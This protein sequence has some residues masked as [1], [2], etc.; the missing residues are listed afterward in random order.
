MRFRLTQRGL[1]IAVV[2]LTATVVV[3]GI[4]LAATSLPGFCASCKSHEPIVAA[5]RDGVHNDVNCELCHSKPGPFFFLTAKMEALE[6]PIAQL[7][8]DYEE[9]ILASVLNQ[10]CRQCH[11]NADLFG[12]ISA[13]GIN[14]Q[15]QHLI[16]AGFLCIRCHSTVGHAA[17][18]PEGSRTY[19]SMDQCLLC[20]NN[21]YTTADGKV[22]VADCELCHTEQNYSDAP[23]S[24]DDPAWSRAPR[25]RRHPLDLQRL[26]S[27]S[28]TRA[29]LPRRRR[30]APPRATGCRRTDPRPTRE[31]CGLCHDTKDYCDTCHQVKMPHPEDYVVEAPRRR[32]R[33][34]GQTCFNCHEVDELPG[35][36]RRARR[37]ATPGRT[38]SSRR[39]PG[40]RRLPR[41]RPGC[42]PVGHGRRAPRQRRHRSRQTPAAPQAPPADDRRSAR[43]GQEPRPARGRHPARLAGRLA[44]RHRRHDRRRR[45][46]AFSALNRIGTCGQCHIIEPEVTTYKQTAHYAAGV[47]CQDCHTKPGVF[48]YFVRNLQ[49]VTHLVNYISDTYQKPVTTYVGRQQLRPL[50]SQ[51]ADRARPRR[52]PDPREP[53]GP[54]RG[55]LPVPDLPRQHLAPR[56]AARGGAHAAGPRS[57]RSAPAVTTARRCPT[58]A[59]SATSTACRPAT[60][61]SRCRYRSSRRSAPGATPA[62]RSAA[63]ATGPADA[64]PEDLAARPRR[65]GP[66]P[67]QVHLRRP[68]TS[69]T[70]RGS[71]STATA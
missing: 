70:T 44:R 18:V 27:R 56:D 48:N 13:Q 62:G 16:E 47:V 31:G 49:G 45:A 43:R 66:R 53:H 28:R 10:S 19:P 30:D 23:A 52:R 50:P 59:T 29:A 24:H 38:T 1:T 7:T 58:S 3:I 14:V 61:R 5:Y 25:R 20:H 12:V 22:A 36:P 2:V 64:A 9:P 8:G 11:V 71:A 46:S 42:E 34:A 32:R 69:R 26:P 33:R 4:A 39:S 65:G 60:R 40:R 37:P 63:T 15:H 6:Q 21:E 55:W 57:C 68:A 51:G 35:V 54:A 41:A 67:R 17:A